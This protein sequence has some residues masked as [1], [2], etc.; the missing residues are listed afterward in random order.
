[1]L[2]GVKFYMANER[3]QFKFYKSYFDV[4]CELSDK[5]RLAFYDAIMK[6]QFTGAIPILKGIV[7]LAYISQQHSIDTQIKGWQ[8]KTGI[9]LSEPPTVPPTQGADVP[10]TPQVK[11]EVKEKVEEEIKIEINNPVD[12]EKPK[13]EY[14]LFMDAYSDFFKKRVD[15]PVKIDAAEGASLKKIIEYITK[16]SAEKKSEPIKSWIFILESFEKW[17]PFHQNQLKLTQINSNLPNILNSI[18]NGTPKSNR[19]ANSQS[20]Q[21]ADFAAKLRNSSTS[22]TD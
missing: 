4:A 1:M 17:Q 12:F 15:L 14:T 18:K 8:D 7:K 11:E 3:L 5:D 2:V 13:S 16:A 6:R 20:E 9:T 10:P 19:S 22:Q 21:L